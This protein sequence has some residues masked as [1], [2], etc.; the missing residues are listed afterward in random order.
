MEVDLPS[1]SSDD[2]GNG[3][4]EG[5]SERERATEGGPRWLTSIDVRGC[6][7]TPQVSWQL[8]NRKKNVIPDK[9]CIV[10]F[11]WPDGILS[12]SQKSHIPTFS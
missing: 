8:A 1:D 10:L 5:D 4:R 3:K 9:Q 7:Y 2:E 12:I 11:H 6:E